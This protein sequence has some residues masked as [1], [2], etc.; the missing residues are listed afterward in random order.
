MF[1]IL[2]LIFDINNM[3]LLI[4][5]IERSKLEIAIFKNDVLNIFQFETQTSAE[6]ILPVISELLKQNKLSLQNI[7]AILVNVGP[8]SYTGTRIGITVAN[9][10]AWTLDIP[11]LGYQ[12]NNISKVIA[13]AKS[14]KHFSGIVLP[15]YS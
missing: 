12:D 6:D 2:P 1:D 14:H 4:N 13:T 7:T 15:K 10:L 11:V 8:G 3:I 5:T 9:T